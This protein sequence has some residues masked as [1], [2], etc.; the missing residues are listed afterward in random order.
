[1]FSLHYFPYE[2]KLSEPFA[3]S[4]NSRTHTEAIY[5][6]IK[7]EN[8]TGY[9]QA[10]FPPYLKER[11][12]DNLKFL[13]SVNLSGFSGRESIQ[14]VQEYLDTLSADNIPAKAAI[15]MA[16][17]DLTAKLKRVPLYELLGL[18]N[19]KKIYTSFTIGMGDEDFVIRQLHKAS[20]FKTL[21]V[22]LGG[23][24]SF[25]KE[26]ISLIRK[27]TAQ[28]VGIDF[29]QGMKSV[30]DVML[31][32][33]WL[34]DKNVYLIEQPLPAAM[35]TE[36]EWLKKNSPIAIFA[37]ES[38]QNIED[39]KRKQSQFHG[40]NIK[41]MKCGGIG[42]AC[43][44]INEAR[45]A[46]MKLMLGCMTESALAVTAAA[47]LASAFERID[48]DGHLSIS[49]DLFA[50]IK[51]EKGEVILPAGTGLAVRKTEQGAG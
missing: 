39:L 10:S 38:V 8:V 21:K 40:I 26:V 34:T 22:K 30:K 44:M 5:V 24:I 29:N 19:D 45:K 35:E 16:L 36:Y 41:L 9:G 37:D 31:M 4:G 42:N 46:G 25:N 15:D 51:L 23:D 27:H 2:L 50:G 43:R 14:E 28:P 7:S 12:E 13:S 48:L 33:E 17:Y 32:M 47:H 1:V 49:N 20:S 18:K 3:V 11:R 6:E